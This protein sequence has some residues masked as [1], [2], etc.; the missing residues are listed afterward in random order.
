MAC[1]RRDTH[2]PIVL[3]NSPLPTDLV[4]ELTGAGYE[5][6]A[7]DVQLSSAQRERVTVIIADLSPHNDEMFQLFPRLRLIALTSTGHDHIDVSAAT[8]RGIAIANVPH[9]A[10]E[11]VA[12]HALAMILALV[13]NLHVHHVNMRTRQWLPDAVPFV[14]PR[15]SELTLGIVGLGRIGHELAVRA[16]SVFRDVQAYDPYLSHGS[17][18]E[19]PC[20]VVSDLQQLVDSSDIVS[21]HVPKSPETIAQLNAVSFEHGRAKYLV[22]VSR[23]GLLSKDRLLNLLKSNRLAGV[24]LD[25]FETEP[26]DFAHPLFAH[27][28]VLLSP[29]VAYVSEPSLRDYVEFPVRNAIAVIRGEPLISPLAL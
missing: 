1:M 24:G 25:V 9:R 12:T 3:V 11:E 17:T 16:T 21:I 7:P 28:S 27:E 13:R 2:P 10:S 26:P 23:G 6:V 29:H 14:P 4:E 20:S 19:P 22:N 8:R 15:L 5:L 18:T